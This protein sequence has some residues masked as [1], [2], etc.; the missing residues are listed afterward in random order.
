MDA[1]CVFR[2]IWHYVIAWPIL[3]CYISIVIAFGRTQARAVSRIVRTVIL[4]VVLC[5]TVYI[6]T[7]T[8]EQ[9]K[10]P[11]TMNMTRLYD[12]GAMNSG[13]GIFS[14]L[15]G[16]PIVSILGFTGAKI[17]ILIVLFVMLMVLTGMTLPSLVHAFTKPAVKVASNIHEAKERK[18]AQKEYIQAEYTE[19]PLYQNNRK[20]ASAPIDI[21]LDDVKFPAYMK[22]QSK[23]AKKTKARN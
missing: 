4:I 8:E 20:N 1:S 17:V 21:A 22:Y 18:A 6:Y 9:Q 13:A 14:G 16:I 7:V 2:L 19:P 3:L 12:Q 10:L 5:A 11:F 15:F 23:P